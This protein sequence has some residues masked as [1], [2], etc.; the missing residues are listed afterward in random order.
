MIL[1]YGSGLSDIEVSK[2]N[3]IWTLMVNNLIDFYKNTTEGSYL[4]CFR[5]ELKKI[6]QDSP[7]VASFDEHRMIISIDICEQIVDMNGFETHIFNVESTYGKLTDLTGGAVDSNK[8]KH[9]LLTLVILGHETDLN[10]NRETI[11]LI[12]ELKNILEASFTHAMKKLENDRQI[13]REHNAHH[14]QVTYT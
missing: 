9:F 14:V 8:L 10:R 1:I 7:L 4:E 6:N 2:Q 13:N 3:N 11:A 5:N 12:E